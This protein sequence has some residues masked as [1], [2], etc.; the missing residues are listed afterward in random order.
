MSMSEI[1]QQSVEEAIQNIGQQSGTKSTKSQ[2]LKTVTLV[3]PAS[4]QT[5]PSPITTSRPSFQGTEANQESIQNEQIKNPE[6]NDSL[7]QLKQR[8]QSQQAQPV[9]EMEKQEVKLDG[10]TAGEEE[11]GEEERMEHFDEEEDE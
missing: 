1:N 11:H 8:N 6:S 5:H 9:N 2:Q 4:P 7:N 3:N 10:I